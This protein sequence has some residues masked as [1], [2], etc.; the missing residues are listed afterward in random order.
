M[1]I[2]DWILL[3]FPIICNGFIVFLFQKMISK[4]ID[5]TEKRNAL[6]DETLLLFW[7]KLQDL[8]DLFIITNK[9][10]SNG[11]QN[12]LKGLEEIRDQ[13]INIVQFYDTNS[14]DLK[15]VS[16]DYTVWEKSWNYFSAALVTNSGK[17]ITRDIQTQLAR[18]F[19]KV[20]D[21]TK[22]LIEAIRKKY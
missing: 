19:Q 10:V 9:N 2:K 12:L 7:R 22:M 18:E 11:S 3:L 6:R 13:V 14:Y 4:K 8:N 21:N 16:E 5:R 17:P 20:K 1:E 15:I